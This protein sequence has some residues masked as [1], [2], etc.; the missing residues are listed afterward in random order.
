MPLLGSG[1]G[2]PSSCGVCETFLVFPVRPEVQVDYGSQGAELV[3]IGPSVE[4][5]GLW[6]GSHPGRI[7]FR[8][9]IPKWQP[10]R[11]GR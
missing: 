3:A 4:Q 2:V 7:R 8:A 10:E 5:E 1:A 9:E 6:L 11:G